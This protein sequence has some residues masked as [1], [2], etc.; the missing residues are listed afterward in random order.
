V[1]LDVCGLLQIILPI[2]NRTP[3]GKWV[4]YSGGKQLSSVGEKNQEGVNEHSDGVVP[5]S[6]EGS[7]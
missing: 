7:R 5:P 2:L 1:E 3:A 6:N 4:H